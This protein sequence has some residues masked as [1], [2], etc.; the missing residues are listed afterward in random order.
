MYTAEKQT[1]QPPSNMTIIHAPTLF[2]NRK[3]IAA[4][5]GICTRTLSRWLQEADIQLPKGLVSPDFQV[6]IYEKFL[7]IRGM[8]QNVHLCPKMSTPTNLL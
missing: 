1:Q 4:E 2:K 5:L 6:L 7:K 8:S 3:V